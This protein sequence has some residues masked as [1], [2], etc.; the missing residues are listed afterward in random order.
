MKSNQCEQQKKKTGKD[1]VYHMAL[2]ICIHKQARYH[3]IFLK[4]GRWA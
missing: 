3:Y 1:T 2:S 4:K